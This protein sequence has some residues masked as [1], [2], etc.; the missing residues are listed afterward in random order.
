VTVKTPIQVKYEEILKHVMPGVVIDL[1][2]NILLTYDTFFLIVAYCYIFTEGSMYFFLLH[3]H[4]HEFK[5]MHVKMV[6]CPTC[7]PS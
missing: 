2:I 4:H 3:Q 1:E 6:T 7:V 5:H